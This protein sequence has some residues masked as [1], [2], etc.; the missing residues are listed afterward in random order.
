[1]CAVPVGQ[2]AAYRRQRGYRDED[3]A[4]S[5]SPPHVQSRVVAS[6]EGPCAR[7]LTVPPGSFG[8]WCFHILVAA[9]GRFRRM[10]GRP[11]LSGRVFS[12]PSSIVSSP[13]G[14]GRSYVLLAAFGGLLGMLALLL[15][16]ISLPTLR[17]LSPFVPPK[18]PAEPPRA[19][20]TLD[21][22]E[23]CPKLDRIVKR[24]DTKP[25]A[26]ELNGA[27]RRSPPGGA[28]GGRSAPETVMP[29]KRTAVRLCRPYNPV[30]WLL[31]VRARH[32]GGINGALG[33]SYHTLEELSAHPDITRFTEW[34]RGRPHGRG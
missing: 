7:R 20:A 25:I 34:V 15:A 32:P 14:A 16:H 4:P 3:L 13:I 26:E 19:R 24:A 12:S 21:E 23:R 33:R 9:L 28:G 22:V 2:K 8:T 11:C 27:G 31:M 6:R 10:P 29:T 18:A 30:A 5:A 17:V 1:M